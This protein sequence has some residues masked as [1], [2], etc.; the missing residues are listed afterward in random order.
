MP[1]E[2]NQKSV[3]KQGGI[4]REPSETEDVTRDTYGYSQPPPGRKDRSQRLADADRAAAAAGIPGV[5]VPEPASDLR[6]R[7]DQ[8]ESATSDTSE[9]QQDEEV[10]PTDVSGDRVASRRDVERLRS[11]R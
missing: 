3:V 5:A 10:G 1:G 11:R 6:A 9:M 4:A 2:T 8:P 7:T